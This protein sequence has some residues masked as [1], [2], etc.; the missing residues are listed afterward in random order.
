[1]YSN[2]ALSLICAV[3]L[4][5]SVNAHIDTN[6][7]TFPTRHGEAI[8]IVDYWTGH[9]CI[10]LTKQLTRMAYTLD[11]L[12]YIARKQGMH[13]LWSVANIPDREAYRAMHRNIRVPTVLP[14]VKKVNTTVNWLK[15]LPKH[16]S[17]PGG[18]GSSKRNVSLT[19]FDINP[20][21][22]Y[23]ITDD[24]LSTDVYEITRWADYHD[25]TTF[26]YAG[27]A[28]NLC[29]T[30]T[31]PYSSEQLHNAGYNVAL[32]SDVTCSE[33]SFNTMDRDIWAWANTRYPVISPL[34]LLSN[35]RKSLWHRW[36]TGT[37]LYNNN[38]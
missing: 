16:F 18:C 12:L 23:S 6:V 35:D 31:R 17:F 10:D 29:V 20:G 37:V 34:M 32:L 33:H 8:I 19:N 9:P 7:H 28:L 5:C 21:L 11:S 13:I 14:V 15:W 1:M 4:L 3:V 27:T 30:W 24:A 36:N 22:Y 2:I 25:I 26:Y 38:P